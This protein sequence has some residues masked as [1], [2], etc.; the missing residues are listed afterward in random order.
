MSHNNMSRHSFGTCPHCFM[1]DVEIYN[2]RCH[3]CA[4]EELNGSIN[5]PIHGYQEKSFGGV[6][7]ICHNQT[8]EMREQA[9]ELG[10]SSKERWKDKK[11]KFKMMKAFSKRWDNMND[12]NKE[13]VTQNLNHEEF[14]DSCK[15]I[16]VHIGKFCTVCNPNKLNHHDNKIKFCPSCNCETKHKYSEKTNKLECQVCNGNLI[17]DFYNN[18]Y[19]SRE[20]LESIEENKIIEREYMTILD[21]KGIEPTIN[22]VRRYKRLAKINNISF[23]S[24]VNSLVWCHHCER[25]ETPSFNSRPNHWMFWAAETKQWMDENPDKVTLAKK[26]II[27]LDALLNSPVITGVYGW[28]I[29]DKIS[30]IGESMD[31]LTRS[32][33]HIMYIFEE[34]DYWYD[35]IDH[36]DKNKIEVK[37]LENIDRND[38]KYK[39]MMSEEFKSQILKYLELKWINKLKPDS[40]RCDGTDHIKPI[41]QRKIKINK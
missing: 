23:E 22:N 36:L 34:P 40:Q 13:I 2:G 9:R 25:W 3:Y 27:G 19:V 30:Y 37:I 6:C 4:N 1:K 21:K 38:P 12:E 26:I 24:F 15:R 41:N 31:I 7:I 14:C 32:W 20:T 5:C 18:R 33:N 28:F 17:Y 8:E 29:N 16:T 39:N 10:T 11:Y 35:V